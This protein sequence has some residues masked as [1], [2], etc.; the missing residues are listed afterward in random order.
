[1]QANFIFSL[2]LLFLGT[3]PAAAQIEWHPYVGL[4]T[5]DRSVERGSGNDATVV[6]EGQRLALG[7]ET[8]FGSGQL[9]PF[10]GVLYRPGAYRTDGDAGFD[11]HRLH[12]PLGLGYR[13]LSPQFDIN[14]FP[15]VAVVPGLSFGD[16]AEGEGVS[17]SGRVGAGLYLDWFT[18]GLYYWRDFG[19]PLGGELPAGGRTLL[20]AGARF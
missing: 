16:A 20:T 1:M 18:L 4:F 15:S 9:T 13:L 19:D 12:V 11:F 2:L 3:V 6:F 5:G 17:W 8:Q 14:V 10:G 7:L